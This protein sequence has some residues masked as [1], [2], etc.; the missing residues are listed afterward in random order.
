MLLISG[1]Y[2]SNYG[3]NKLSA[4]KHLITRLGK[5]KEGFSSK[6]SKSLITNMRVCCVW[7]SEKACALVNS[8]IINFTHVFSVYYIKYPAVKSEV[9]S[10]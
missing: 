9:V 2:G 6:R 7:P 5:I 8:V 1:C 10:H 3:T 4:S